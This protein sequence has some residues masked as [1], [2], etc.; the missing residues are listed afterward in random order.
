M[1]N[2]SIETLLFR[3]YGH[4]API[5]AQM[6]QQLITLVRSERVLRQQQEYAAA[7]IRTYHLSRRRVFKL[8]AISSAGLGILLL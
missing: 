3:H 6:E 8:I 2:D 4:T 5:P 7:R 1:H